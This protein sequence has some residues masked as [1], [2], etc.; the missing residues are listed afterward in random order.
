[1]VN[2][3]QRREHFRRREELQRKALDEERR[4]EEADGA[5]TEGCGVTG[6]LTTT[7]VCAACR[8]EGPVY[9]FHLD[10]DPRNNLRENVAYVCGSC[11]P[12]FKRMPP[13]GARRP[14]PPPARPEGPRTCPLLESWARVGRGSS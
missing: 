14:R 1:M 8:T 5:L 4:Y 12:G 2:W 6:P 7:G 11:L 13:I 9:R 3:R 10:R